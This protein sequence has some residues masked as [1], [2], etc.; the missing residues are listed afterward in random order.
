MSDTAARLVK[1]LGLSGMWGFDFMLD[2]ASGA[3]WLIEINPR[4][5]PIC[6]LALGIGCDLPAAI[7]SQLTGFPVASVGRPVNAEVIALFP[8]E[9]RR[10]AASQV[11]HSAYHDI[12]WEEPGLLQDAFGPTWEERG[13]LARLKNRLQP[14]RLRQPAT[15]LAMT[16]DRNPSLP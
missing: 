15:E 10:D 13:L 6:H 11:L 7:C 1:R 9:W 14:R 12:P 3:A 4:A 8:G 2:A 16:Y 5:T